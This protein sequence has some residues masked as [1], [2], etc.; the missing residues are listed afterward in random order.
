[1]VR[2]EFNLRHNDRLL[3]NKES[4]YRNITSQLEVITGEMQMVMELSRNLY[5]QGE[6]N[7]EKLFA[8][9]RRQGALKRKLADIKMRE[10][11]KILDRKN[12]EQEKRMLSAKRKLLIRKMDK[13]SYL[14]VIERH[15]KRLKDDRIDEFDIEERGLWQR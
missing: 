11:E 13:Y 3:L 5:P 1:M 9:Q 14:A 6:L 2:S 15:K 10:S 12:C 8:I 7:K 4:E